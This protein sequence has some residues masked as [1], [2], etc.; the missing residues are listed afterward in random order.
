MQAETDGT[1]TRRQSAFELQL[2][3]ASEAHASEA[4]L[5][6]ARHC[7]PTPMTIGHVTHQKLFAVHLAVLNHLQVQSGNRS[8][9]KKD[10]TEKLSEL[11]GLSSVKLP[12]STC[13]VLA[14]PYNLPI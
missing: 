1:H 5:N 7:N 12:G 4:L 10:F 11:A 9:V 8:L 14:N 13:I 3:G 6:V 2:E